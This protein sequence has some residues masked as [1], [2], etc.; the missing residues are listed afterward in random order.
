MRC[1][2]L[3]AALVL[4]ALTPLVSGWTVKKTPSLKKDDDDRIIT[5]DGFSKLVDWIRN[6]GGRF[7]DRVVVMEVDGIRG[8]VAL[9]DID[10]G[11]ELLSCPWDLV[12][13]STSFEE[14]LKSGDMCPVVRS[15][16]KE[17]RLGEA[18]LWH[19]YLAL[20]DS[21]INSRLPTLWDDDIL[22]ELQGL[23][24]GEDS[25]RHIRWFSQYCDSGKPFEDVDELT[26]QA[27]LCFIT[28]A[29][30]VGMVPIYDLFNH[31][32]GLRNAKVQ[33]TPEGVQ[34]M[35]V[36]PIAKGSQIYLSYGIKSASTMFR[37]YGFVESWPQTWSWTSAGTGSG[38]SFVRFPEGNIAINPT[39]QFLKDIWKGGISLLEFQER[40]TQHTQ[41]LATEAVRV[42]LSEA[43]ALLSGL[44]TTVAEDKTFLSNIKESLTQAVK[45]SVND[46]VGM[47]L[48]KDA[49][50]AVEYRILFKEAVYEA[51]IISETILKQKAPLSG[52]GGEL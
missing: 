48:L 31:H 42:F 45:T 38:H 18:S 33:L 5:E 6:N 34:L 28:R 26:K 52:S 7:D 11:T 29:S 14:Q 13:G 32:N 41:E 8:G 4:L 30:A 16:E 40:A 27:L 25:T 3:L 47:V 10:Q 43:Y 21:I 37:D 20:D 44:P 2:C 23:P 12:I 1:W 51:M 19:P 15:I 50:S 22:D 17:L 35:A 39:E 36:R 9:S 49:I 46:E 24:P